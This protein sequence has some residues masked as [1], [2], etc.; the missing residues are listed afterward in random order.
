MRQKNQGA[1]SQSGEPHY[2]KAQLTPSNQ[3]IG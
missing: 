2:D 3:W 1:L